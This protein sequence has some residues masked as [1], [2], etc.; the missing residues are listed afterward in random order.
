MSEGTAVV[1]RNDAGAV[2]ESVVA[3][4]DLAQLT[5][6]ERVNYYKAVC[7]SLGLNALTRPFDYIELNGK[8]TLY[9]TRGATDQLRKR[10][11]ISVRILSRE[12][13]DDIYVVTVEATTP[14]GRADTAIGAV[15]LVKEDGE[16]RT[17]QSG[18]R[19]F[20]K[21]GQ[22]V[23]LRGDERANA[24]M[25][26][27]TKA[28]RR[29]TLS[30][31]GLGWL[32]ESEIETVPSARRVS[33]DMGTGEVQAA[34]ALAAPASAASSA[35]TASDDDEPDY[36]SDAERQKKLR[37]FLVGRHWT[38]AQADDAIAHW[39]ADGLTRRQIMAAIKQAEE[40]E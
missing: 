7:D 5:P 18:K 14:D 35:P 2:I 8:L 40:G 15:S 34:P 6:A 31:V 33:V 39:T 19:Y 27:E 23:P 36:L 16:W 32:D 17:S 9:A 22:W 4:G 21:S 24:I 25:K 37:A 10:D 30:I 26:A 38:M 29:V 3:K 11:S 12:V 1:A 13:V 28:K 20:E